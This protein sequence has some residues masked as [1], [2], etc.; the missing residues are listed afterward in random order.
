MADRS[1][2]KY[3]IYFVPLSQILRNRPLPILMIQDPIRQIDEG[4]L[5]ESPDAFAVTAARMGP[6]TDHRPKKQSLRLRV[7]EPV[8]KA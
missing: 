5:L 7:W 6:A 2:R 3:W 8:V 1:G 4:N